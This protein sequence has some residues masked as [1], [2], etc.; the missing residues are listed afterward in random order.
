M[1]KF[2]ELFEAKR[3]GTMQIKGI[4]TYYDFSDELKNLGKEGK[5]WEWGNAD[6]GDYGEFE[7]MNQKTFDAAKKVADKNKIKYTSYKR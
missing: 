7:F 1:T 3:I 5:D 4:D 6:K 2:K